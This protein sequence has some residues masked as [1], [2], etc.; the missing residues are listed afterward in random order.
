[1]KTM[2]KIAMTAALFVGVGT[3]QADVAAN[4]KKNCGSC[5]GQDGKGQTKMGKKSGVSD[6]TDA[7]VQAS[8]TD[9]DAFKATKEGVKKDGK[10]VMKPYAAKLSDDEIKELV[11]HIRSFKQ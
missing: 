3:L 6:Y 8:F 2:T 4:W 9:E 1:M 10:T 5:H 7:A 11:A